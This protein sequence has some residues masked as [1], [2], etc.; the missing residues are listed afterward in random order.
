MT[1]ML[2]R[3]VL[4]INLGTHVNQRSAVNRVKTFVC[5]NT[6]FFNNKCET[7]VPSRPIE[8]VVK[9]PHQRKHWW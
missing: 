1:E 6:N 4:Y 2:S 8:A 5:G 7:V 3:G 9:G